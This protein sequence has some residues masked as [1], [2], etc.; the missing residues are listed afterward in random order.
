MAADVTS[1]YTNIS[2]KEGLQAMR[3]FLEEHRPG[4]VK[5]FND[6]LLALLTHVLELNNLQ[7]NGENFI[8][9]GDAAMGTR[10]A[11]SFANVFMA[12]FEKKFMSIYPLQPRFYKR[13][14][15]D[16]VALFTHGQEE[17]DRWIS[18]LNQCH[19]SIKFTVEQS[20]DSINFLD[21]KIN[22]GKETS[23]LWTDL[24]TKPTDSHNYLHFGSAHLSHS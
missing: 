20:E 16:C 7:F 21:T 22:I 6:T 3:M 2:N 13:Y 18:Y 17:L 24:Y 23:T 14:I 11:P 15:D 5:P 12:E 8:Q 4:P 19:S 1:L 9:V 10:V